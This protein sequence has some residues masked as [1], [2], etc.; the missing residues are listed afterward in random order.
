MWG[1]RTEQKEWFSHHFLFHN[2]MYQLYCK[3]N[4]FLFSAGV[5]SE[6]K[7]LC[8]SC[9]S[10]P[11]PAEH[12]AV[13]HGRCS[14]NLWVNKQVFSI[15]ISWAFRSEPCLWKETQAQRRTRHCYEP[16]NQYCEINEWRA[17]FLGMTMLYKS[18]NIRLQGGRTFTSHLAQRP[19]RC[20]HTLHKLERI[21]YHTPTDQIQQV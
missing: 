20:L 4:W 13:V 8:Q 18:K 1:K 17:Y 19:T 14:V 15:T 10:T 21:V 3:H 12:S 16:L 2:N 6:G 11:H 9:S 5:N 7:G